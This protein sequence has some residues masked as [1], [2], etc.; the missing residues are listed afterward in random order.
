MVFVTNMTDGTRSF[1][2]ISL[3]T[4][5]GAV[6]CC[7]MVPAGSCCERVKDLSYVC[8]CNDVGVVGRVPFP[9]FGR[10]PMRSDRQLIPL[11]PAVR[12]SIP[13]ARCG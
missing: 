10:R 4:E 6:S 2:G 12:I 7:S 13:K 1:D 3:V 8:K 9:D 5:D 11:L